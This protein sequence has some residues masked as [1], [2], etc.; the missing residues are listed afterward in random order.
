MQ[1]ALAKDIKQHFSPPVFRKP[2]LSLTLNISDS[3]PIVMF[4][5]CFVDDAKKSQQFPIIP[6]IS[7]ASGMIYAGCIGTQIANEIMDYNR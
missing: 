2:L 3:G 5:F 6:G 7:S 1:S 4:V